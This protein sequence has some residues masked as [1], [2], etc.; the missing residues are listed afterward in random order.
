MC[1]QNCALVSGGSPRIAKVPARCTPDCSR[2]SSNSAATTAGISRRSLATTPVSPRR[3][4]TCTGARSTKA[5]RRFEMSKARFP[6]SPG[7]AA[8]RR[9]A[10]LRRGRR[11]RSPR[12]VG[13]STTR[14]MR[15][16]LLLLLHL[17]NRHMAAYFGDVFTR[18]FTILDPV[19]E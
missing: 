9:A 3:S 6:E 13:V 11:R 7:L 14:L 17:W 12:V 8:R 4:A 10:H 19:R 5:S 1:V 15:V 18:N 16:L 2:G